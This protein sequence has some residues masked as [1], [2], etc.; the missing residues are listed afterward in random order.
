PLL[1]HGDATRRAGDHPDRSLKALRAGFPDR[2]RS[3]RGKI[4]AGG[5]GLPYPSAGGFGPPVAQ[6]SSSTVCTTGSRLARAICSMQPTL[7]AATRAAPVL[8]ILATL[9]CCSRV[10]ISGCSML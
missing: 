5:I 3:D 9:R 10:A 4:A 1:R 6:S 7:P 2:D 8:S